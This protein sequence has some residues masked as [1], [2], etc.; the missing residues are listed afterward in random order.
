VATCA[1]ENCIAFTPS[2]AITDIGVCSPEREAEVTS[3]AADTERRAKA[4]QQKLDRLDE[5]FLF[6]QS[7]DINTYER[8]R[9]KLR[10]EFTLTQ[11]DR[12]SVEVEKS[13]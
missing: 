11:I 10:Q 9:D 6:A 12:H 5:A 13:T 3:D 8:Q 7:I 2:C 1:S 4:I